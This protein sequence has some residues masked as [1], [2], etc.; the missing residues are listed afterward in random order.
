VSIPPPAVK[1]STWTRTGRSVTT[2]RVAV[3]TVT[4]IP[5]SITLARATS[6]T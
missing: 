2:I 3:S 6:S 1:R 4:A 5:S